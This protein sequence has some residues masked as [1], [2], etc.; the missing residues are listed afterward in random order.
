MARNKMHLQYGSNPEPLTS[1]KTPLTMGKK[2]DSRLENKDYDP[3]TNG[4]QTLTL[5]EIHTTKHKDLVNSVS[6]K[7]S[8]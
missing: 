4:S 1:S 2:R 7:Q 5:N 3:L 8:R 6:N